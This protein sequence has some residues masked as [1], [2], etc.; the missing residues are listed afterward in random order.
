MYPTFLMVSTRDNM[1]VIEGK[2]IPVKTH[3]DHDSLN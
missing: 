3:R 1:T 2:K